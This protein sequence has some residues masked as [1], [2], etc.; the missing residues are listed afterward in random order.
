[1]TSDLNV[2]LRGGTYRLASTFSL[3]P[4]DS[5]SNGHRVVYQAYTGETPVL[6]GAVALT[7]FTQ[8]DP[9]QNIWRASAPA[10]HA[11]RQLYM[12]GLRAERSR[13]RGVLPGLAIVS[14]GI[15]TSDG[16][17]A[18]FKN[19]GEIELV[20]DNDWRHMSCPLQGIENASGGGSLLTV[21]PTCWQNNDL[22]VANV[23][24]PFNG[25]GL[26]TLTST[27]YIGPPVLWVENAYELLT[28]PGQFYWDDVGSYVYYIPR[29]GEDLSTADAE[30]PTLE[31]LVSFAGTPGHLAPVDETDGRATYSG[32]W[33]TLTGRGVGDL[34]DGVHQ[35]GSAGDSVTF[36]FSGT[37]VQVLGE[38]DADEGPFRVYVDGTQDT[39]SAWTETAAD[40][41]VQQVV[42]SVTGLQVGPHTLK[43]VNG[44]AGGQTTVID[45][46]VVI[47][48]AIAPVHD[49][50]FEGISFAYTTWRLPTT[51]GYID[52]Q[53]GVLWDWSGGAPAPS[54]I[55]AA[56][57]VH[58]GSRVSLTGGSV[59]H[60]GCTAID[61]ADGTQ[62]STVTGWTLEDISGGGISVGEADDYFQSETALMTSG[63]FVVDNAI[64]FVGQDYHDAVGIWAGHARG[65][66]IEHNDVGHTPYSGIS[67][68]WGWGWASSC[69]LQSAQGLSCRP[70]TIYS[71]NNQILDNYVHDVMGVLNDGG[72][73]YTNG[74]QGDGDGSATSVLSGNFVTVGNHTNYVLYHDEGSSYW[75][76]HDNVTSLAGGDWLGMWTPTIHDITIGPVNYSDTGSVT[77]KGTAITYTPPTVVSGGAWP[78][79]AVAIMTSA[80]L[81]VPYRPTSGVLD[82]DDPS[83]SYAGSWTGSGRR[84]F[85]DFDDNVHYTNG[86][87][88]SVTVEFTG[89]G[90]SLIGEKADDQGAIEWLLD[91]QSQGMVDTSLP[92]GSPRECQQILLTS[93]ALQPGPHTL[94]IIKRG[95]PAMTIDAVKVQ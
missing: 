16:S 9:T 35:T 83:M 57:Q 64:S 61:L 25:S 55:P 82:D 29:S 46:F 38:T 89:T 92:A 18:S 73:I 69:A 59:R 48:E 66:R 53:A 43:L 3:G 71:G 30:L 13:S 50:A 26:P 14:T 27:T 77:N 15:T 91:G 11:G 52:N 54:R 4:A 81:E 6:T 67:L 24:F 60:V 41:H 8:V 84:G 65:L 63:D 36:T 88:D 12:N 47:P 93:P 62:D 2:Y 68:G 87:G 75:D 10:G 56:V 32:S 19:Q 1:M 22:A 85:G 78:P 70:G 31:T 95:G 7:G 37:G 90:V 5:G 76:T 72:P 17:Y 74:G 42:C 23:G 80:G 45:G 49:I 79:A 33:Q 51:T 58:R 39:R 21:A 44:G 86:D 34:G 20:S 94:Q 28:Q 40:K